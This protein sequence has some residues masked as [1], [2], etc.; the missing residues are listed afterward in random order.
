[1]KITIEKDKY[2]NIHR[3][4]TQDGEYK[5]EVVY[6]Y[7][8][9]NNMISR[10]TYEM[11]G[12]L[13]DS[14]MIY[15]EYDKEGNL[16]Y[17]KDTFFLY[18]NAGKNVIHTHVS[19]YV[20]DNIYDENGKLIEVICSSLIPVSYSDMQ[21][22]VDQNE[23]KVLYS[24]K[25]FFHNTLLVKKEHISNKE[26]DIP[27]YIST[28]KYNDK[29]QIMEEQV[30]LENGVLSYCILYMYIEEN[31]YCKTTVGPSRTHYSWRIDQFK[32]S[33]CEITLYENCFTPELMEDILAYI[34]KTYFEVKE[35]IISLN[36]AEDYTYQELLQKK[37]REYTDTYNISICL[38]P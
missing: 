14:N 8:H 26:N 16:S 23:K 33:Y 36:Y 28:Y 15:N 4:L 35:L 19:E 20:Y 13:R 22:F 3:H 17:Q 31:R 5:R 38:I 25:F 37:L 11:D 30:Y 32:D 1:M 34:L 29:D 7:N 12:V 6:K 10:E 24:E 18:N 2:G 9:K 21:T 27:V